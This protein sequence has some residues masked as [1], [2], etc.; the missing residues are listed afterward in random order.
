MKKIILIYTI[1]S[2][3]LIS[4]MSIPSKVNEE[5][6][7]EQEMENIREFSKERCPNMFQEIRE[8]TLKINENIIGNSYQSSNTFLTKFIRNLKAYFIGLAIIIIAIALRK[9]HFEE[10]FSR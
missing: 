6:Y 5:E 3:I 7:I 2:L 10:L 1:I 4:I 8:D 9:A